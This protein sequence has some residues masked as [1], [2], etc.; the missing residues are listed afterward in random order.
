MS[1]PSTIH[2]NVAGSGLK[3]RTRLYLLSPLRSSS[4]DCSVQL[5]E[6]ASCDGHRPVCHFDKNDAQIICGMKK[7]ARAAENPFCF[8]ILELGI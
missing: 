3:V 4:S 5:L 6:K 2:L 1:F 8:R 7:E